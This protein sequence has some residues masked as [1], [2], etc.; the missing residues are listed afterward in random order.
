MMSSEQLGDV[1]TPRA[2]TLTLHDSHNPAIER[3]AQHGDQLRPVARLAGGFVEVAFDGGQWYAAESALEAW[4]HVAGAAPA[5]QG[6]AFF[7]RPA[8]PP[9][10][11]FGQP[12]ASQQPA[13]PPQQPPSP[14]PGSGYPSPNGYQQQPAPQLVYQQ[15]YPQA[16]YAQPYGGAF[17]RPCPTCGRDFGPGRSCQFCRAVA[18]VPS[19]VAVCTPG[20][21]LGG[22]LMEI[23][24]LVLTLGIGWLI[25]SL[26][27]WGR[28]QTPGKQVL[29]MR[30]LDA[31]TGRAASWGTMFLREFVV[32]W[33]LMAIIGLVT[34]GVGS[35]IAELW[36]LWDKDNQELWDK[37]AN[38]MVVNDPHKLL[39][40]RV[41]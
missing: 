7:S 34:F 19:G 26:V 1:L 39:D 40:P 41:A 20:K 5:Q 6:P 21:R 12:S 14:V 11:A 15:P 16:G 13:T 29:G 28:G 33:L 38:T 30:V 36:L 24:M 32:K 22:Y 18:G 35:L 8:L 37:V 17:A 27:V 25:W 31:R 4:T 9:T 10:A 3:T 23:L 2:A